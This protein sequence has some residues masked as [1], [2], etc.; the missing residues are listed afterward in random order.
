VIVVAALEVRPGIQVETAALLA[1]LD[2]RS[3]A[4]S[5]L[6]R[7]LLHGRVDRAHVA[8]RVRGLEEHEVVGIDD[9]VDELH[10][11]E[12][13]A[14]LPLAIETFGLED[15]RALSRDVSHDREVVGIDEQRPAD[16]ASEVD[17]VLE[18]RAP[19]QAREAFPGEPFAVHARAG[20]GGYLH[21]V[22]P[23]SSRSHASSIRFRLKHSAR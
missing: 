13:Q 7:E 8:D 3:A 17:R 23:S 14:L 4:A 18:E 1:R 15:D 12:L 16:R 19:A 22:T 5:A 10:H 20:D 9:A 2:D 11:L 6:E 21:R